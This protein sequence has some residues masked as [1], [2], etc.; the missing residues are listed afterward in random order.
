M[1]TASDVQIADAAAS[2]MIAW[3]GLGLLGLIIVLTIALLVAQR[4]QKKNAKDGT[5][6]WQPEQDYDVVYKGESAMTPPFPELKKRQPK[7]A[8]GSS[9]KPTP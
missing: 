9:Q 4:R 2:P 5:Y 1:D 7:N 6:R 8:S 3:L